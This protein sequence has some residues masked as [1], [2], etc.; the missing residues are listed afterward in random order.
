M[1]FI[2]TKI[3]GV[4]V[5]ELEKMPDERG[6]FARSWDEKEFKPARGNPFHIVQCNISFNTRA[7]TLRG[8]HY[9]ESP[10]EETKVVRCT[11]GAVYDVALDLRPDSP[12]YRQWVGVELTAENHR[13]LYI[14]EGCA[15]GFQTLSDNT[16][17]SYLMGEYFHPEAARGVRYDD[18]AF[19][20]TWPETSARIV[21]PKDSAYP[22]WK[23]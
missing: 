21:S 13:S 6:F 12:A 16:E 8:M 19:A 1:K 5:V 9:Q 18:P 7:G 3:P 4:R 17:V 14:P 15:H 20:I 2:E 11:R 10:Y 22:D 23:V